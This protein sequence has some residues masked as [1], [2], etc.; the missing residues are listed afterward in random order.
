MAVQTQIIQPI[1]GG[2]SGLE[3]VIEERLTEEAATTAI[4]GT[5]LEAV[6]EALAG[7]GRPEW[8][9]TVSETDRTLEARTNR[10]DAAEITSYLAQD[11]KKTAETLA[12]GAV[13]SLPKSW[14]LVAM[15]DGGLAAAL[16]EAAPTAVEA[17]LAVLR[18]RSEVRIHD[19]KAPDG[20]K[21]ARETPEEL[22]SWS[23]LHQISA[24]GDPHLHLH[25]L[26]STR[27]R[28]GSSGRAGQLW[29]PDILR[30]HARVAHAAAMAEMIKAVESAGYKVDFENALEI[31]G[32]ARTLIE[33]ASQSQD[34]LRSI[35]AAFAAEGVMMTDEQAW[36]TY[37]QLRAGKPVP[38]INPEVV[39]RIK[40]QIG[41]TVSAEAIEHALDE[42]LSQDE[43]REHVKLML[44]DRY[45]LKFKQLAAAGKNAGV[46]ALTP[47][48]KLVMLIEQ[49]RSAPR[50]SQVEAWSLLAARGDKTAA[51]QV[52]QAAALDP[53]VIVGSKRWVA[54]AQIVQER[55]VRERVTKL[56]AK[57]PKNDPVEALASRESLVVLAGVAGAGKSHSIKLAAKSWKQQR[58]KVWCVARNAGTAH[59]LGAAVKEGGVTPL[60]GSLAALKLR[61]DAG[62][63][64][65]PTDVLIVDEVALLD[66]EHIELILKLAESGVLVRA[67]GDTAQLAPIDG[68]ISSRA[69]VETAVDTG[70]IKLEV[71]RRCE[72]WLP[73]HDQLRKAS[74]THEPADVDAVLPRLKIVPITSLAE[75]A[76]K[77]RGGEIICTTNASRSQLAAAQARPQEPA[78]EK[79]IAQLRDGE[80]GWAGDRV[81][82]RQNTYVD[83]RFAAAN[84]ERGEIVRVGRNE[85]AVMLESGKLVTWSREDA[86][87]HLALGGAWT[88]ASAQ[89][90]TSQQGV[91]V[92]DGGMS[93]QHFYAAMTRFKEQPKV[94]VLVDA[95]LSETE[96]I[97]AALEAVERVLYS[98]DGVMT[99]AELGDD[100]PLMA[101]GVARTF[102][103]AA[104]EPKAAGLAYKQYTPAKPSLDVSAQAPTRQ[105][106]PT[107]KPEIRQEPYRTPEIKPESGLEM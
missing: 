19:R 59:D 68:T 40:T 43:K 74:R 52:M 76:E 13:V 28:G 2:K 86:T 84:G 8:Y 79:L 11:A 61:C 42:A 49:S 23:T 24:A 6:A 48:D 10:S 17:Y 31:A 107:P 15:G 50:I 46:A 99:A 101:A 26:I 53:R 47:V 66:A 78:S 83:N 98:G 37:R 9:S 62:R 14:S 4:Y 93:S 82:V 105:P 39:E 16:R 97:V 12:L 22:K 85:L 44:E 100:D 95:E 77:S 104:R 5:R 36:R 58:R 51:E 30:D 89:G 106:E 88:V 102:G 20:Q 1:K 72:A 55:E 41:Q 27:A 38:K 80:A 18:E 21:E 7:G 45:D 60:I 3:R 29:Q 70:G 94:L 75:A 96:R 71:S 103:L 34:A 54:T 32:V 90:M 33:R 81:I 57:Y 91:V 64:P 69:F 25:M 56:V 65:R 73:V 63:G 67:A 92:L 87:T 35:R